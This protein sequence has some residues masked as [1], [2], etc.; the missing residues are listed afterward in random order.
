MGMVELYIKLKSDNDAEKLSD[1]RWQ[2]TDTKG[3]ASISIS[4][5]DL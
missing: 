4:H 5:H 1:Y 3:E 2:E